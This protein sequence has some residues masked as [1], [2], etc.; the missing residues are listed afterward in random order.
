MNL[1]GLSRKR[2]LDG[3]GEILM[4]SEIINYGMRMILGAKRSPQWDRLRD[5][6]VRDAGECQACNAKKGLEAHHKTPVHVWPEGELIEDNLIVLCRDCHFTFGHLRDWSSWN[7]DVEK[8]CQ[9]YRK[10]VEARP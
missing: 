1:D 4:F 3:D 5:R 10:K 7:V 2:N 8:D 6:V 9:E